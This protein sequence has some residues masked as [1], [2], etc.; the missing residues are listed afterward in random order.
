MGMRLGWVARQRVS[1]L[2]AA[3]LLCVAGLIALLRL[4]VQL[5]PDVETP[6]ISIWTGWPGAAAAEVERAITVPQ[7]S[8]MRGL[9]GLA[10]INANANAGGSWIQMRFAPGTDLDPVFVEVIGR[11]QRVPA[12][13]REATPPVV[14]RGDDG[15]ERT[16]V[17]YFV[18]L[19]PGSEGPVE[20]HQSMVQRVIV[21]RLE[22]IPGV[23]SA[24]INSGPDSELRVTIDPAR[25][26]AFGIELP[27]LVQTLS[28]LDDVSAGSVE[29]G[30]TSYALRLHGRFNPVELDALPVGRSGER[31]VTLSEI[32]SARFERP[33]RA[34]FSYQNGNPALTLQLF[35]EP[36]TNVLDTLD[37]LDAELA[38]LRETVLTPAGLDMQKSF[39][40]GIFIR[41]AI[42][43]L[44]GNLGLGLIAA[45]GLL[46]LFLRDARATVLIATAVP[47]S[48]LATTLVL[49]ALGKSLNM[50]SIAGLAFAVGMV[51]DAAIVVVESALARRAA[52]VDLETAATDGAGRVAGALVAAT[53]TTVAVF[54]P[55]LALKDV[56]GQVFA[57]LALTVAIAV[58]VSLAV[59]LWVVPALLPL[60][61]HKPASARIDVAWPAL[62]ARIAATSNTPRRAV[63]LSLVL[64]AAPLLL[65]IWLAPPRDYLP[66]VKR[67]AVDAFLQTPPGMGSERLEAEIAKPI[68]E[69]MRPYMDGTA[70]PKLLNYYIITWTGGATLGARVVDPDRIGELEKLLNQ[71]ILVGLPDLR[72]FAREGEL[73]GGM[74]G[75]GRTVWINLRGSDVSALRQA[76]VQAE[77]L[78]REALPGAQVQM[79][80]GAAAEAAEIAV[81]PD[82]QRLAERGLSRAWLA[83]ALRVLGDGR[84]L[85]EHFDG[86]RR[87]PILLRAPNW[88]QV[89]TLAATPLATPAGPVTLGELA[90]LELVRSPSE[91]RRVDFARAV[92]LTVDPAETQS[93]EETLTQIEDQLLPRIRALLPAG[94]SV[95]L[96][97]SAGRLDQLTQALLGNLGLA[98]ITLAV[99][100]L[101]LLRSPFDAAV[102]LA[103]LPLAALGGVI[104]LNVLGWFTPQP[105]DLLTMIGFVMLLAMV[106]SNGVLLVSEARVGERR[107]LKLDAAI[108]QALAERLRPLTLGA[109]TGVVGA[110]PLALSPGPAASIYRGLAAVTCGGVLLSLLLVVFL[111][112]ALLRLPAARRAPAIQSTSLE[113]IHEH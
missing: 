62:A 49:A 81:L 45:L 32:G 106:V 94:A 112:P 89:D 90:R 6:T 5:L 7:E 47:I 42:G 97:G 30:R 41:R 44:T 69:R 12:L 46:W 8:V 105:L 27:T 108:E 11:L 111:V 33:D 35:R 18:Q 38:L 66:P 55:V 59:A 88:D 31:V 78:L 70:E 39:E 37:A 56:E 86:E 79:I 71:K 61:L 75:S 60:L 110:L 87:V 80:P 98:L 104:G 36:G 15:P 102:V 40:P 50:I 58:L 107:G 113:V 24:R 77:T 52:G 9:D 21:P 48:L 63:V 57:D 3:A 82:D 22:R 29:L 2:G 100:L 25:A 43:F 19:L 85:G 28:R 67:A 54:L 34:G 83:D 10:E 65:A 96:G 1:I 26:A 92:T 91:L 76:G 72:A 14:N 4:P 23:A 99:I 103:T 68:I 51:M 101:L 16:L 13:P 93:L 64:V 109:L 73:F 17:Y 74:G 20:R 53:L 84:F 95:D